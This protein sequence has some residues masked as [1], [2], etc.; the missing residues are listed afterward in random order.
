[1]SRPWTGAR[2]APEKEGKS[3][4]NDNPPKR[5]SET[6]KIDGKRMRVVTSAA[7]K[8]TVTE[9]PVLEWRLQAAQVRRLRQMPEHGRQF[10]LVGGMEAGKRGPQAAVQAQATG[11]EPGNPDLTILLFGGRCAFIEN[12]T[13]TGRLSPAQIQRHAALRKIGHIVEVV[14][15]GTEQE[16]ADAAESLVR[17]WLAR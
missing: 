12:K 1:M 15:V 6:V 3:P 5:K 9:A 17:G 14:K 8:T 4:A 16:A 7:G 10:L 2:K 13:L 11:L